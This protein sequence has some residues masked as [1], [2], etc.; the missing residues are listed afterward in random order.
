MSRRVPDTTKIH[1]FL[2]W[3]AHR[4]L[5]EILTD[6]IEFQRVSNVI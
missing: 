6:V 5:E 2:G 4:S 3:R 1:D